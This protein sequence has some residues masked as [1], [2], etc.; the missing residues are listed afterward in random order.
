MPDWISAIILGVVEGL[1]E[2]IPVSSTGHLLLAK[3]ALGLP[4]GFWDTFIVLIQLGAI[5]GVVALYFRKLWDVVL[6]LPTSQRARHFALSVLVAFLP[7][8]LAGAL[9]HDIIKGVLFESPRLI[10][11][12]LIIGG[13]VLLVIDRR[14]PAPRETDPMALSLK[15]SLIV[16]LFQTLALIPGVSRSGGTIVGA[17]LMGVEKRAAAEFSFF[18]A[19][20]TMAGAFVLDFWSSRGDLQGDRIGLLVLGFVVSFVV[21]YAV[22][23]FMLDF[24]GWRGF[25]PFGWWRILVGVAGLALLGAS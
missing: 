19:M 2:F 5:L 15:T 7:G 16:G 6:G 13:V 25:A 8:A 12:S 17:M 22:V 4:P 14:A 18:L 3:T 11:W 10:C 9:L 20:P 24:I 1:T 23:R 21:G